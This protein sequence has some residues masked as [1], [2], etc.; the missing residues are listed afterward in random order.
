MTPEHS[1]YQ[2]RLRVRAEAVKRPIATTTEEGT[3]E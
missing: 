3:A 1:D 2:V